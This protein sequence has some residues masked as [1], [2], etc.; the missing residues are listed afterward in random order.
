MGQVT[1]RIAAA[2]QFEP[3]LLETSK[4]VNEAV[5]LAFEAAA[6]GARIIVLPELCT[7]GRAL[8]NAR[9][10]SRCAQEKDG[11]QTQAF[12]P[13]AQRFG[14]HI[15]FGYPETFD[16]MLYN[17]AA[18]VGPSGLICNAR[19]HNLHGYDHLWAT[20]AE[21]IAPV[22]V[23]ALDGRLGVLLCG[24]VS[25]NYRESYKF[26]RDNERFYR[27]GS[28]DTICLL[29]NWSSS[30]EYPDSAWLGLAEST[31]ANVIVSNRVGDE[32]DLRFKG[33]SCIIDRNLNVWTHGSS[34]NETAVVGGALIM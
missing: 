27:P 8:R 30:Y 31:H 9:D 5:G 10:A 6:K 11:Y 34:F 14:C 15:V 16:G 33:G 12:V 25:N 3:T 13:V 32:R 20:A 24:D 7:S 28:V 17:S 4:N 2:V 23:T 18:V 1:A 19:K 26:H 29:T 21:S 22:A